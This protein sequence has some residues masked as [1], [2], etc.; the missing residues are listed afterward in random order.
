[1]FIFAYCIYSSLVSFPITLSNLTPINSL[2]TIIPFQYTQPSP[3]SSLSPQPPHKNPTK[4]PTPPTT[5][6]NPPTPPPTAPPETTLADG[7][8]VPVAVPVFVVIA[9]AVGVE[10]GIV[11]TIVWLPEVE[12]TGFATRE[13]RLGQAAR[14]EFSCEECTL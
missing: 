2:T 10:G 1:M 5:N 12:Q 4:A 7:V 13:V 6:I 8:L 11:L 14:A 3:P 9:V